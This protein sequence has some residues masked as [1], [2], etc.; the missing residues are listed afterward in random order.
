MSI[1]RTKLSKVL[2]EEVYCEGLIFTINEK[3]ILLKCVKVDEIEVDHLWVQTTFL[4]EYSIYTYISFIATVEAYCKKNRN[5]SFELINL[6]LIEE[7]QPK[8]A[9]RSV[10]NN[11]SNFLD[12]WNK[13]IIN[14]TKIG[15]NKK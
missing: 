3:Y 9:I 6:K 12:K 4:Q 15:G 10:N 13:Y 1:E 11:K 7:I 14:K 5:L 8:D 2:L